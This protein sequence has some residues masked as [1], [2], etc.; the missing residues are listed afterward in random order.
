MNCLCDKIWC[1][2]TES[3]NT[4]WNC[5]HTLAHTHTH[6]NT[7]NAS[8]ACHCWFVDSRY[9]KCM[10]YTHRPH[11]MLITCECIFICTA[12]YFIFQFDCCDVF[13][14]FW[15]LNN[16]EKKI[17]SKLVW[18]FFSDAYLDQCND[19]HERSD[20]EKNVYGNCCFI[21]VDIK[22]Q[23]HARSHAHAFTINRYFNLFPHRLTHDKY[24]S[25]DCVNREIDFL[26]TV[27]NGVFFR[28]W[29]MRHN[30]F[31]VTIILY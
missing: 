12:F 20:S 30:F 19:E 26:I 3:Y 28:W 13:S 9:T 16:R 22:W 31:Y 14:S 10:H 7:K 5:I 23:T 8:I 27:A 6:I 4:T 17:L 24:I 21:V 11:T 18:Y 15:V 1:Q 29:W 25:N 2:H